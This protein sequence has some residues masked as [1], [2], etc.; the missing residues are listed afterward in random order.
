MIPNQFVQDLLAR[1]DV[2]EVVGAHVQ[3][4]KAG[5]N[6]QGLCPF[7][8]EK[9]PSFSVSPSKQFYHCFGCGAH[10]TALGFMMEYSG[11]AF[12]EAVE[13]LARRVGLTVP[14]DTQSSKFTPAQAIEMAD[15]RT[16]LLQHHLEAAKYY[17]AQ[18]K[19]DVHAIDYLKRRGLSGEIA[20]KFGLGYAPDEWQGL[21]SVAKNYSAPS[22]VESGL[23]IDKSDDEARSSKRY[24]RF[25]DRIMFPIRGVKGEIIGFGGRIIDQ[26]EPKYLNSPETPLFN[27]GNEL[28]G[29]FEAR[30][31]IRAAGYALVTEGYMDVVALAQLGFEQCVAT[32]GTAVGAA[33]VSKLYKYTDHIVF[34]FDGDK[35]GRKAAW[36]AL[37]ASLPLVTDTRR[38]SFLFLPAGHDPDSFIRTEGT[39]AFEQAVRTAVPLSVFLVKELASR[40]DITSAEGRSAMLADAKPMLQAVQAPVLRAQLTKSFA[41]ASQLPAAEVEYFLGVGRLSANGFSKSSKLVLPGQ[42]NAPAFEGKKM[43]LDGSAPKT[44]FTSK[45]LS[46]DDWKTAQRDKKSGITRSSGTLAPQASRAAL[47]AQTLLQAPQQYAATQPYLSAWRAELGSPRNDDLGLVL[48]LDGLQSIAAQGTQPQPA[49]IAAWVLSQNEQGTAQSSVLADWL[50][51]SGEALE[52]AAGDAQRLALLLREAQQKTAEQQAISLAGRSADA[53]QV[54]KQAATALKLTQQQLAQ[55]NPSKDKP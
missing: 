29:L 18:L 49:S 39:Q 34:S 25:R 54:Y 32:L 44:G 6:L 4:R 3:L 31:A 13:E 37:E 16:Q 36:R 46:G 2:V 48:L 15:L 50:I 42:G 35:A 5:A 7:H 19:Q 23:V 51:Q 40:H 30:V 53:M 11:Y 43:Q 10:G 24:D 26:G 38:A 20:A 33:H 27:K 14:K 52:P 41:H 12:P 47:L 45:R 17:K 8:N 1:T 21:A 22:W 28:Y 55:L 9:S